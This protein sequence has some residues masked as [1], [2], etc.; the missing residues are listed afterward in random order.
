MPTYLMSIS[1]IRLLHRARTSIWFVWHPKPKHLHS[2]WHRTA[3]NRLFF[4]L[5]NEQTNLILDDRVFFLI[6]ATMEIKGSTI[7]TETRIINLKEVKMS[8][9]H[10]SWVFEYNLWK[11]NT[12]GFS[13]QLELLP[14]SYCT[15]NKSK[16]LAV[17]LKH[18]YFLSFPDDSY[19]REALD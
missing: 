10:V 12:N 6:N 8:R 18:I 1:A 13:F 5:I 15:P 17:T 11:A 19:I 16:S 7:K 3:F 9:L 14:R 2:I 4:F